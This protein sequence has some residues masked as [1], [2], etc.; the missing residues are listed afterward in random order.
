M[1][2]S[3]QDQFLIHLWTSINFEAQI[4]IRNELVN[5]TNHELILI[6]STEK[7]MELSCHIVT[8]V[9]ANYA[10]AVMESK[11]RIN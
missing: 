11:L 9:T 4:L 10:N 8:T 1:Y 3:V 5:H 6:N 7:M 2:G